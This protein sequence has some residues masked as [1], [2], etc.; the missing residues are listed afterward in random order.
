M[1]LVCKTGCEPSPREQNQNGNL[2]APDLSHEQARRQQVYPPQ[3]GGDAD[4]HPRLVLFQPKIV[5]ERQIATP[6]RIFD[7]ILFMRMIL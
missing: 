7:I 3:R 4:P 1:C 5:F 6:S 2:E